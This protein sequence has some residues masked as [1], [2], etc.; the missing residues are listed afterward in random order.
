[1]G[2]KI[3]VL[4]LLIVPAVLSW[5]QATSPS[6]TAPQPPSPPDEP[7][8]ISISVPSPSPQLFPSSS[9]LP[10][11]IDASAGEYPGSYQKEHPEKAQTVRRRG[12]FEIA[13][14][15]FS[16]QAFSFGLAPV[17]LYVFHLDPNDQQSPPSTL[18]LVGMLAAHSSWA[19]GGGGSLYLKGDRYRLTAF[20]GHGTVG[21]DL[22]GVGTEGGN[23]GQAIPIRQGGDL[24]FG[25]FLFRLRA[26][27]YLGPRFNY[28]KLSA[29]LDLSDQNLPLPAGL[30]PSDLG[31]KFT[32]YAPGVKALHD[33]RNDVFYP[34]DGHK[35]EFVGDFFNANRTSALLPTTKLTYQ[36]YQISYNQYLP[37]T[38]SQVLAV[39][40]MLCAVDGNPPFYELCQ[41]GSF[42]DIRGY[43]PGRYRDRLMFAAQGEYRKILS[44]RWGFVVFGGLG[45]VAHNWDSFTGGN[46]LPAGGTGVRFNLS[47]K[48]RI[49]LR[50]DIAYGKTGWSWNFSLGE[51]F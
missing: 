49:N 41:Y 5:S 51:A 8:K 6:R 2:Q 48:Q 9:V 27:F 10:S 22:Y 15:P 31:A 38:P 14:I 37:L 40:G 11:G 46:L 18:A 26:K 43:Q 3:S 35:A 24:L 4:L 12:E 1:M 47:K 39:R 33:T 34:T 30:D 16:N 7:P 21:Y 23:N 25:E 42:S 19:F 32:A 28:R 44:H 36:S 50:A 13:P 45:E 29:S 17:V 20:G